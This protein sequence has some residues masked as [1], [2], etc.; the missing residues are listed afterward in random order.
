MNAVAC[1][2]L[3]TRM[4]TTITPEQIYEYAPRQTRTLHVEGNVI[5][6][7]GDFFHAWKKSIHT[8]ITANPVK[9]GHKAP[10]NTASVQ[11]PS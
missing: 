3:Y 4:P 7:F 9:S 11:N 2:P 10:I 1:V 5:A 6:Y 8:G